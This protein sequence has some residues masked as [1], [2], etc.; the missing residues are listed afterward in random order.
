VNRCLAALLLVVFAT[1]CQAPLPTGPNMSPRLNQAIG[2]LEVPA[3]EPCDQE[4]CDLP[5]GY[6]ACL[7]VSEI[8]LA[9]G[10][11]VQAYDHTC[12]R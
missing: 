4:P 9:G 11:S 2:S 6:Q 8:F 3:P 7:H 1:A 5:P 10:A 12:K